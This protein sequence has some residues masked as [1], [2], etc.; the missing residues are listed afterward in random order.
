M[1][2]IDD[3]EKFDDKEGTYG[4]FP[5]ETYPHGD[6][7]AEFT[8]PLGE[9]I[10]EGLI[11]WGYNGWTFEAYTPEIFTRLT[12]KFNERFFYREICYVP[13]LRWKTE[14]LSFL[15]RI[16]PK[17]NLMYKALEEKEDINIFQDSDSYY[18]SRDITSEYPQSMLQGNEDYATRGLDH[19]DERLNY[20]D[21]V[22]KLAAFE[23]S[24]TDIDELILNRCEKFFISLMSANIDGIS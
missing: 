16:M 22:A 10:T 2:L 21:P 11:T 4:I 24:Y 18:K 17:Y 20:G 3:L 14:L 5:K 13:L 7:H 23:E 8:I 15:R 19:E 6:F 9:L 12:T 1:A